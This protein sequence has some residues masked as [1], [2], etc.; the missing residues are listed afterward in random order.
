MKRAGLILFVVV[1]LIQLGV[2]AYLIW[3]EEQT[4]SYGEVFKFKTA[5]VDPVD[6]FRGRY[7]ALK[8]EQ[9]TIPQSSE[10]NFP[11]DNSY[12]CRKPVY[13]QV[14]NDPDGFARVAHVST[15]RPAAGAWF[16]A[17]AG[18]GWSTINNKQA[19][20]LYFP[21]DAYYMEETEAP[22]AE[23]AYRETNRRNWTAQPRPNRVNTTGQPQPAPGSNTFVT[24]RL[25]NGH[26]TLEELYF[27][28]IAAH[29]YLKQHPESQ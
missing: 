5:P 14:G 21:F 24:V 4:L 16:K 26:A 20:L 22:R 6:A 15:S 29:E 23:T 13:V 7:V 9:E 17:E 28:G 8:F 25:L 1:M 27:N 19:V 11:E 10:I 2:P 18:R 12:Y 3:R